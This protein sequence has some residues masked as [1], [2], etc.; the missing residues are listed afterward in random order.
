M[1]YLTQAARYAEKRPTWA[2]ATNMTWATGSGIL[3]AIHGNVEAG[4]V[5]LGEVVRGISERA[6]GKVEA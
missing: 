6:L 4:K 3:H 1:Q 5:V 2:A